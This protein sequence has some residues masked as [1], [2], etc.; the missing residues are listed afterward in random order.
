MTKVLP[1]HGLTPHGLLDRPP[2]QASAAGVAWGSKQRQ[3][4]LTLAS[5]LTGVLPWARDM[6]GR[7]LWKAVEPPPGTAGTSCVVECGRAPR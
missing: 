2:V 7:G 4:G 5:V 1:E 6:E 3:E